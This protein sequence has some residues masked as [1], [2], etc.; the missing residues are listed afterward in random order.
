M[1]RNNRLSVA[2]KTS[3]HRTD[4]HG[5]G[6]L[7]RQNADQQTDQFWI[8]GIHA[9]SAAL[10]NPRRAKIRLLATINARARLE[11]LGEIGSVSIEPTAPR[12]LDRLLGAESVHQG[13]ALEVEPLP[14]AALTDIG[15]EARLLLFLDQVTDPQ[16]VGAILRSAAA[17]AAD[18]VVVTARHSPAETGV[19]AKAASGAL[20]LVP[21]IVVPNL[22][23][24]L[25]EIGKA[26]F[27]R[28]GLDSNGE[29]AIEDAVMSDRLVLVLGAEGKGL[30]RLTRES[31]DALARLDLPGSI[32]TLNVSN[33]AALALYVSHRRQA[34]Y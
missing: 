33:A 12:E 15:A 6:R 17:M 32:A 30:R 18:A 19:L 34:E 7:A 5:H 23:R 26:G 10:A 9:V 14:P 13:A 25:T 16:N 20:D 31:C 2:R 3:R 28:V 22:A 8:W 1:A 24:A 29:D 11:S 21:L 4:R 27:H